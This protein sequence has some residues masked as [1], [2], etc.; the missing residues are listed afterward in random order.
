[1][2]IHSLNAL[3]LFIVIDTAI[4][5]LGNNTLSLRKFFEI[6]SRTV[7]FLLKDRLLLNLLELGLEILQAGGVA[8][9][10]G[11][12]TCVGKVESFILDF[13][14]IN[15]PVSDISVV[16]L[17]FKESGYTPASL[18]CTILLGLLGIGIDMAS[19]GKVTREVL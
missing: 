3:G 17:Q 8:A 15:T 9:A 6:L 12:T 7:Q 4:G 2:E 1:M 13:L 11:A 10:V 19:L 18:S 16:R 5:A 14:A